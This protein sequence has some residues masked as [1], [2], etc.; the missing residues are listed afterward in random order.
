MIQS[1]KNELVTVEIED[2]GRDGEGIGKADGF[3]L[4]VKDAIV[5]DIVEARIVKAKKN[6]AYARLEKVVVPSPFRVQPKCRY[7][8]QCGGCQLQALSYEKQLEFK[9]KKI[10]DSLVRI[11]GFGRESVEAWMEPILGMEKPFHYRNKAQ[12]PVGAIS[13]GGNI[14]RY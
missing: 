2:I 12:Y 7:H 9:Q 4:F 6:Y 14:T 8:R 10:M 11:G 5:G 3:P 13:V 1:R